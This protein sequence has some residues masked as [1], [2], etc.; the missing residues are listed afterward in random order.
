MIDVDHFKAYNDTHGHPAGDKVLKRIADIMKEALRTTDVVARYGGEEFAIL[1]VDT[2]LSY[3]ARVA[4]KVRTAIRSETFEGANRSQPSGRMTIS[5]GM[6]GWPI[7]GK[8]PVALVE[9]ADKALYDAKHAGRD[10]VKMFGG[11]S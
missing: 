1:L 3:A 2:P 6:A 9:A 4:D 7:H 5:I 8:S 10:Q 11:L